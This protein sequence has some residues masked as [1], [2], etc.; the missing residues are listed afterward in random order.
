MAHDE[1]IIS[2]EYNSPQTVI[3]W[4][5]GETPPE[6]LTESADGCCELLPENG[7]KRYQ[8]WKLTAAQLND[9]AAATAQGIAWQAV[10]V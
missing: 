1:L 3:L 2:P 7:M 5:E 4:P 8:R 9:L 6:W 10:E